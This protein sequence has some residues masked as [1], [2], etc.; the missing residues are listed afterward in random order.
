MVV[1]SLGVGGE[2]GGGGGL[3][4]DVYRGGGAVVAPLVEA[5]YQ[6]ISNMVSWDSQLVSPGVQVSVCQLAWVLLEYT[7]TAMFHW[8]FLEVCLCQ[9]DLYSCFFCQGL[10]LHN[11]LV[12]NVFLANSDAN[13]RI[14]L[15]VGSVPILYRAMLLNQD[16]F[17]H[18][19][20]STTPFLALRNL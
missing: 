2:V 15:L 10:H 13:H 16:S 5:Q 18:V 6:G 4:D 1:P 14:Y 17:D 20:V 12:V 8:M 7:R 11:I 3:P 19:K 9:G